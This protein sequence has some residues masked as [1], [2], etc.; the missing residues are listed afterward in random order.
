MAA[1]PRPNLMDRARNMLLG[2]AA[3]SNAVIGRRCRFASAYH[4]ISCG[5][6]ARKR[7]PF[8]GTRSRNRLKRPQL[9][10][11]PWGLGIFLNLPSQPVSA[12]N[13]SDLY[14]KVEAG[15]YY[16]EIKARTQ[17]KGDQLET[18]EITLRL[19]EVAENIHVQFSQ[20]SNVYEW[21]IG[22][23][24]P[25][26]LILAFDPMTGHIQNHILARE[27]WLLYPQH[28]S[29]S[30][31]AGEGSLLEIL[32][33]LPGEWSKLKLECWDLTQATC[34]GLIQNGEVF[35]EIY[36]RNQEKIEQPA[37]EGGKP[38]PTDLE[39]N[40]IPLYSGT[41]PSL[42]IFMSHSEELRFELSRWKITINSLGPADPEISSQMSLADLPGDVCTIVDNTALIHLASPTLLTARPAG[43]YQISIKGPLGRDA[44]L[45][46][47]ILPEC[48]VF[49]LKELYIP[50]RSSGPEPISFSIQTSL[51]AGVDSLNGADGIKIQTGEIGF[52]SYPGSI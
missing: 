34:I 45:T 7:S 13:M 10:L 6:D 25:D 29:L 23:Y 30:V 1:Q 36:I 39:E 24:S 9:S 27:T 42:R 51:F 52:A 26:H 32:P 22:G 18:R 43:A 16:E 21:K 5:M 40:P 35:R 37:L 47:Q 49:G 8:Y 33:D 48:E 3:E 44:S 12:L 14:W 46:L 11:D 41:P 19:N 28:L 2:L 31:Q 17:R 50:D 4:T 15:D 20:G 38:I